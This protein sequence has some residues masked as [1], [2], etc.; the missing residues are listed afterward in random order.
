MTDTVFTFARFLLG[1]ENRLKIFQPREIVLRKIQTK[2]R[3]SDPCQSSHKYPPPPWAIIQWIFMKRYLILF[4]AECWGEK[5]VT[6]AEKS[7]AGMKKT[8]SNC[9]KEGY[10]PCENGDLRCIGKDNGLAVYQVL[11]QVSF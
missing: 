10:K 11:S 5:K 6:D 3:I 2:K 4:L 7:F 9:I 8:P 1:Q